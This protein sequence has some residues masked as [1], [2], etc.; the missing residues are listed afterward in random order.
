VDIIHWQMRKVYFL[1]VL[2]CSTSETS[3]VCVFFCPTMVQTFWQDNKIGIAKS[4]SEALGGMLGA[5]FDNQ[6]QASDQPRWLELV[7][8]D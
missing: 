3:T 7:Q 4:I 1:S 2:I 5:D 6:S 8:Y